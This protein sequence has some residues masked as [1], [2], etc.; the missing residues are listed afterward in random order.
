MAEMVVTAL[1]PAPTLQALRSRRLRRRLKVPRAAPMLAAP[2]TRREA[3]SREISGDPSRARYPK[4]AMKTSRYTATTAKLLGVL[5]LVVLVI[6]LALPVVTIVAVGVMAGPL[7]LEGELCLK[8]SPCSCS[9]ASLPSPPHSSTSVASA[10]RVSRAALSELAS[11]MLSNSPTELWDP[12]ESPSS[13]LEARSLGSATATPHLLAAGDASSSA[14]PSSSC[15]CGLR[16][17]DTSSSLSSSNREE[18][19]NCSSL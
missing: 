18:E 14:A 2:K 13:P 9:W 6:V 7:E 19:S 1:P 4:A 12:S 8:T 5:M 3:V 16:L 10:W 15:L 17:S 11:S